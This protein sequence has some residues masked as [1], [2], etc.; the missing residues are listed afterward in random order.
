VQRFVYFVPKARLERIVTANAGWYML[1]DLS[2][3]FP[4][5]LKSTPVTEADLRHA[6]ALPM[7]VLL[8]TADVDPEAKSLRHTP[9]ADAQGM[10]RFARGKFFMARAEEA[11]KKFQISLGWRLATAPDI[12]HSDKD[13]APFAVKILF[14]DKP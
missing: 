3:E 6:L 1:P 14:P 8:G 10:F 12:A 11:A 9:E 4:Y 2:V 13:M 7:T 5:G